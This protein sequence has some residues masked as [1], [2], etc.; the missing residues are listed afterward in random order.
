V[1]LGGKGGE[2]AA[3]KLDVEAWIAAS[4]SAAPLVAGIARTLSLA[5]LASERHPL[6][7]SLSKE[8]G[9]KGSKGASPGGGA[10]TSPPRE[11]GA[12]QGDHFSRG[13]H[14]DEL[15]RKLLADEAQL[16]FKDQHLADL[17]GFL[18]VEEVG[19]NQD[20]GGPPSPSASRQLKWCELSGQ[21]LSIHPFDS[22]TPSHPGNTAPVKME[23]GLVGN[24]GTFVET[25]APMRHHPTAFGFLVALA[26]PAH[27]TPAPGAVRGMPAP[28]GG[29]TAVRLFAKD[30]A[31]R[32]KWVDRIRL[33]TLPEQALTL[34]RAFA[35]PSAPAGTPQASLARK[36]S[37]PR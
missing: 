31:A 26:A 37:A 23:V 33:R 8:S 13:D 3:V 17:A 4:H 1:A 24:G 11:S 18:F 27:P 6:W 29:V 10:G 7:L 15:V 20:S 14:F 34:L 2:A 35:P 19:P 32:S 9:N 30:A 25:L 21:F 16:L 28:G 22:S 5:Q 12:G 36:A